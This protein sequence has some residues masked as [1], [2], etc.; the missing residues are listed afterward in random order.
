ME[1]GRSK[2]RRVSETD[3]KSVREAWSADRSALAAIEA[4][5]HE[6]AECAAL[7]RIRAVAMLSQGW[8]GDTAARDAV[9]RR[10]QDPDPRVRAAA[11]RALTSGWQDDDAARHALDRLA[12]DADED[13]RFMIRWSPD[14]GTAT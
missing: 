10:A 2:V 11:G 5:G 7:F 1:R 14:D 4:D 8:A 9:L 13:V 3:E 6:A 12:Q